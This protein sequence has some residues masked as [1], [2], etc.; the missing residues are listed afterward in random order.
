MPHTLVMIVLDWTRP[1]TFVDE[2]FTWLTWIEDWVKGET[3]R[4]LVIA[5]EENRERRESW[6]A[7]LAFSPRN[8]FTIVSPTNLFSQIVQAY[9]QHYTEPSSE[10]IPASSASQAAILPLG[11]GIYTH[12]TAGVPIIVT[13]TKSDLID[14]NHNDVVGAGASG[15]GGMVKGKGGEWEER[16]DGV[17]QILRTVCLKCEIYYL[18][19]LLHYGF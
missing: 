13:C 12:N 11:P 3:P 1:W 18:Q 19:F 16:T 17:M 2:L 8:C 5:R 9:L 14:D 15:M 10:P 6:H 4:E 7:T